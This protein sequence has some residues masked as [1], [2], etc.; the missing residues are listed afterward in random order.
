MDNEYLALLRGIN[1]GGKSLIKMAALKDALQS[2]GFTDVRTY[3]QSGNVFLDTNIN[4]DTALAEALQVSI[5]KHFG[6]D[7]PV[8]AYSKIDW[9][10]ILKAAP[11]WWGKNPEWKHNLLALIKPYNMQDVLTVIGTIKPDIEAIEPGEGVL[12]Q[13]VSLKLF[14]RTITGKLA[15]SP[16]YKKMTIRNYNTATKLMGLFN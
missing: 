2:D 11:E 1:V 5:Q 9:Q 7:V 13:G 15:S 12:Y 10:K 14:G 16:V 8:V 3:I 6:I 4:D